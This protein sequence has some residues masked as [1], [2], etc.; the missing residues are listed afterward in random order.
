MGLDTHNFIKVPTINFMIGGSKNVLRNVESYETPGDSQLPS[1]M[2]GGYRNVVKHNNSFIIGGKYVETEQPHTLYTPNLHVSGNIV[3]NN[4]IVS[5]SILHLTE[6]YSDG[7]TVFGNSSDDLHTFTGSISASGGFNLQTGALTGTRLTWPGSYEHDATIGFDDPDGLNRDGKNLTI[8]AQDANHEGSGDQD[9]GNL[10]L[11]AGSKAFGGDHGKIIVGGFD[12]S[13]SKNVYAS[14]NF[15]L[16]N[17]YRLIWQDLIS[18]DVYSSIYGTGEHIIFNSGSSY[19]SV[20]MDVQKKS[21]GIGCSPTDNFALEVVGNVSASG[22]FY[23]L[24]SSQIGT[25][26]D[27]IGLPAI[28]ASGDIYGRKLVLSGSSGLSI[29]QISIIKD[30]DFS[31]NEVAFQIGKWNDNDAYL[32]YIPNSTNAGLWNTNGRYH[33]YESNTYLSLG[34]SE[35]VR[36]FIGHNSQD[37]IRLETDKF[38]FNNQASNVDTIIKGDT[39]TNLFYVDASE[40]NIGI[41]TSTP[42]KKLE[43][44]GDI[45]ASGGFFTENSASIGTSTQ[46]GMFTVDYGT[47]KELTGSIDTKGDGYGDVVKTFG[48]DTT[49][50]LIY[51]MDTNG[52]TQADRDGGPVSSSLLAV[53]LGTNSSGSGM[54][55]RGFANVAATGT[56]T[57]GQKVYVGDS[58]IVTG[59]ISGYATGDVVRVVG[60]VLS[61]SDNSGDTAAVYFNPDNTWITI[62]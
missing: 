7:S 42:S 14:E 4:Y 41:G 8:N 62:A 38:T 45:S 19:A 30:D 57:V 58:G 2:F 34:Y 15:H 16:R 37:V 60:Y 55:L 11:N 48:T 17:G 29:P 21:L 47:G 39:D 46:K 44:T 20:V 53:S 13:G 36:F 40:D 43:V 25:G 12:F 35:S 32:K 50:G 59:S 49:A 9:G 28:S 18:A 56:T 1:G 52:W 3:A 22:D 5:S 6:S 26:S 27:N 23:T 31:G 10:Y 54:L 33:G 51:A 61:G 24:Y